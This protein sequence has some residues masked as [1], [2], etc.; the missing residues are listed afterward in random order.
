MQSLLARLILGIGLAGAVGGPYILILAFSRPG[1]FL[2]PDLAKKQGAVATLLGIVLLWVGFK[3][4][5]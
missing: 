3:L 1:T 2:K 4:L 5:H